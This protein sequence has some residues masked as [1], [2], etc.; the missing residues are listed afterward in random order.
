MQVEPMSQNEKLSLE[1]SLLGVYVTENPMSK[2]LA[3][4]NSTNLLKIKDLQEKNNSSQVKFAAIIHKCKNIRTKKNNAQ[5][6]FLTLEDESGQIEA[7]IFPQAFESYKDIIEENKAFYFEGKISLRDDAKSVLIDLISA[8]APKTKSN[9]DFIIKV[10]PGTSQSQLMDL[11]RLLKKNQN[12]HRGLIVLP[13]GKE[14]PLSY[15]VNY[16]DNLKSQIDE[17][18]FPSF[19]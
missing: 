17:I 9:Y 16:N 13:N 5:M 15:G 6:A 7:V 3:N 2:I 4:F 19:S 10:P 18:F 14:L 12:G 8:T 1:K 11:D